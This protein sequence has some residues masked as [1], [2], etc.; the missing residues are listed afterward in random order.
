[1]KKILTIFIACV[2]FVCLSSASSNKVGSG[3]N[4][5]STISSVTQ[6]ALTA[7]AGAALVYVDFALADDEIVTTLISQGYSVTIASSW[8]DFNTLLAGGTDLAVAFAQDYPATNGGL[9]YNTVENYISGGGKMIF[10][11]WSISDLA[12]ANLFEA[13]FTGNSNMTQVC[14]Y[15]TPLKKNL[16]NFC[17]NLNNPG[18]GIFSLGLSPVGNG[19][20]VA[21]FNNG[22]AAIISGNNG[23]T[24]MLGYLSDSPSMKSTVFTNVLHSLTIG[25]AVPFAYWWVI[26]V[27]I[28]I[29]GSI[30]Y[31][32]RKI[33]FS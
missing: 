5:Y 32:K 19:I 24:I 25:L 12:F 33:I 28:L 17:F 29:A 10:A 8:S 14:S 16:P 11:T 26:L 22:D 21:T 9:N 3:S 6:P 13:K 30:I 1:M 15:Y 23:N 4:F 2:G 31:S 20:M 18:W 27:F 7:S